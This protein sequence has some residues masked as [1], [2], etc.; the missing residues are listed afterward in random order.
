MDRVRH[1]TDN[2][3]ERHGHHRL[4]AASVIEIRK[5]LF[6][7]FRQKELAQIYGVFKTT[8]ENIAHRRTWAWLRELTV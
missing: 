3:G 8:I 1:G 5:L 2:R 7:G 6:I 4:D